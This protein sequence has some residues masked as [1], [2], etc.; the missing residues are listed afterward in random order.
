MT[1]GDPFKED[2]LMKWPALRFLNRLQYIKQKNEAEE[3]ERSI[4][5]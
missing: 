2:E 1:G 3:F 4:K 5:K